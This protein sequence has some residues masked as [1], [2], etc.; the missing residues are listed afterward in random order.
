MFIFKKRKTTEEESIMKRT[1]LDLG[2]KFTRLE[3]KEI[4]E[5][6]DIDD[7]FIVDVIEKMIENQEV[8]A[9]YLIF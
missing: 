1:I 4:S 5:I 8:Y 3:V 6:C 7:G 9:K 2:T